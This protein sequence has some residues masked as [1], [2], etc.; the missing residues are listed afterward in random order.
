MSRRTATGHPMEAADCCRFAFNILCSIE[1]GFY[2]LSKHGSG[3]S[4]QHH[5]QNDN[6]VSSTSTM[7]EET[8]GIIT[9]CT[10]V[11]TVPSQVRCLTHQMTGH[12]FTTDQISNMCRKATEDKLLDGQDLLDPEK[13]SSSVSRIL[14]HLEMKKDAS[15]IAL[16]QDPGSQLFRVSKKKGKSS[17]KDIISIMKALDSLD[18]TVSHVEVDENDKTAD[19]NREAMTLNDGKKMLLFVAWVTYYDD[20]KFTTT[21]PGVISFDTTYGT[22]VE[23][24]P[25][26]VGAGTCNNRMNFPVF[27]AFMPS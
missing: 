27:R 14:N 8:K 11:K 7:D 22:N 6:I 9:N 25:L 26:C 3:R 21:I 20:F 18:G 16:L 2:Y 19:L 23:R 15:Y 4:H 13:Q 12:N 5:P 17:Y 24:R 10:I 1:D